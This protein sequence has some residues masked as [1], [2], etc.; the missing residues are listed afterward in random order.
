MAGIPANDLTDVLPWPDPNPEEIVYFL[1]NVGDRDS[2][3]ILLPENLDGL[4]S[5]I[6]VDIADGDKTGDLVSA[7]Q[8]RGLIGPAEARLC[9][10]ASAAV[11]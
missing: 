6:L 4:R 8:E 3:V 11:H 7:L 9:S 10:V 5:V 1:L 2:Q